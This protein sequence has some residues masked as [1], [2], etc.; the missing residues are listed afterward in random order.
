MMT[1]ILIEVAIPLI[2]DQ[3]LCLK[4]L[5][6]ANFLNSYVKDINVIM[7]FSITN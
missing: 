5:Y 3:R 4:N 6:I 7:I 1:I 2:E